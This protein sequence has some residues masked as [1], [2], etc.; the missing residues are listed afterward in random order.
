MAKIDVYDWAF[1]LALASVGLTLAGTSVG[2]FFVTLSVIFVTCDL[3]AYRESRR[4][5]LSREDEL[6]LLALEERALDQ[7]LAQLDARIYGD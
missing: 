5:L 3:L 4:S 6:D 2:L 7:Q 1:M